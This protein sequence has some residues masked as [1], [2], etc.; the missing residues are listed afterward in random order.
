[1]SDTHPHLNA[2]EEIER[3]GITGLVDVLQEYVLALIAETWREGFRVLPKPFKEV[4]GE[5]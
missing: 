4:A 5:L 3:E 1:M 2:P